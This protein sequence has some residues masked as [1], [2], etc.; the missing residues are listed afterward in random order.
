MTERERE[1]L[2][3]LV[4][5]AS[6]EAIAQKLNITIGTVKAY[7]TTIF[8]KMQVSSRTQAALQALKLGLVSA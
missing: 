1:V 8:E 7:L 6:N 3:W 2:H 5:G 4:Q